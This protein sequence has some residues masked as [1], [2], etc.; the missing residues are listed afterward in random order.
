MPIYVYE[1]QDCKSKYSEQEIESMG[2]DEIESNLLFETYHSMNPTEDELKSSVVCPRCSS[3]KCNKV[4]TNV[5]VASY[6]RGYGW[7]DYAGARRDMN[8]F[9]LDNDDPY[10]KHRVSGEVDH[11]RSNLKKKS[12]RD[13]KTKVFTT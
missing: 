8:V 11:I 13:P 9:H 2:V 5:T 3:N 7:K 6:T 12:K 1:C 4:Y 10:K